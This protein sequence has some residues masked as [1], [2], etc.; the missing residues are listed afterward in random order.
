[1]AAY[2]PNDGA[3]CKKIRKLL[4]FEVKDS[5][6]KIVPVMRRLSLNELLSDLWPARITR[7]SDGKDKPVI[8]CMYIMASCPFVHIARS[9]RKR[10]G[11][12]T[13]SCYP[14]SEYSH[15]LAV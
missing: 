1:M 5:S 11:K 6:Q 10:R 2:S 4:Q 12:Y 9:A 14:S 3:F 8:L 7:K 15:R 13:R